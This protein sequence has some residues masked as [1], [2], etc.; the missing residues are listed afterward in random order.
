MTEEVEEKL[1]C[2]SVEAQKM[3][4][5]YLENINCYIDGNTIEDQ[6][7]LSALYSNE[8]LMKRCKSLIMVD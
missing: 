3:L 7:I 2:S 5:D 8:E 4:E 1:N 6:V